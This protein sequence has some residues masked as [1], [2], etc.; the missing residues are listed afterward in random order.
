MNKLIAGGLM[1][2]GILAGCTPDN[3]TAAE[4]VSVDKSKVA[5]VYFS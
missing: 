5:V 2:A 3:A 1:M 4:P